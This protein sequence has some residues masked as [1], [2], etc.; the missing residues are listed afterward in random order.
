MDDKWVREGAGTL[1]GAASHGFPN[2]F[3]FGA[4]LA[5]IGVTVNMTYT[6]D[7]LASHVA[8]ILAEAERRAGGD[9]S[10][11]TVEP[12]KAGEDEW[13]DEIVK[14]ANWFAAVP[15]CTPSWLN[16]EGATPVDA[17]EKTKA[18]RNAI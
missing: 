8:T 18:A 15:G 6:L 13:V 14:R 4:G 17:E 10:R 16:N 1:H 11:V 12:T 5:Q 9:A 7:L 3:F 2:L